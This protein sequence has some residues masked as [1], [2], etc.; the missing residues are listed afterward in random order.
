[1]RL[2]STYPFHGI[3]TPSIPLTHN[4]HPNKSPSGRILVPICVQNLSCEGR[5][6]GPIIHQC[7]HLKSLYHNCSL[8]ATAKYTLP[9]NQGCDTWVLLLVCWYLLTSLAPLNVVV[10]L[11]GQFE[12]STTP[13]FP[14]KGV[15]GHS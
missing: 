10:H 11:G 14:Y 6:L 13:Q 15:L 3:R 12:V 7:C 5:D 2:A 4:T 9:R 8:I 1:M